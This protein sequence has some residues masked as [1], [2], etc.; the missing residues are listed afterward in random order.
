MLSERERSE[1]SASLQ[2]ITASLR[3]SRQELAQANIALSYLQEFSA[4]IIE[5]APAGIA[6]VDPALRVNYWN[7]GMETLSGIDR[8]AAL[9]QPVDRLLPWLRRALLQGGAPRRRGRAGAGRSAATASSSAPSRTPRAGWSSSSRTSPRR[10]RWRS[11]SCSP[12]SSRAS[13]GSPPG[14]RTRSATRWPR[15]PRS[16]RSWPRSTATAPRGAEF[17]RESLRSITGHLERI[18]R[19]VRSLGDFARI[20][21]GRKVAERPARDLPPHDGAGPLRQALPPRPL[22]GGVRGDPAA[23]RE[24]RPDGAGLPQPAAQRPGRDARGR[25]PAGHDAPARG[26]RS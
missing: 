9:D 19:I 8:E 17:T 4:N 6:T 15:S 10:R 22:P 14:S 7:R 21:T 12:R 20:S 1:L 3:L 26:R 16:C 18:S 11:S 24:P 23:A 2:R 13:G 5:S 25:G